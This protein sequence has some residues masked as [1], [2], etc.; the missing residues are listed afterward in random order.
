[1]H[2]EK[3]HKK[4]HEIKEEVLEQ[5]QEAK[6]DSITISKTEYEELLKFKEAQQKLIYVYAEFENFK[7]RTARDFQQQLNYANEGLIKEVLPIIDNLCRAKEHANCDLENSEQKFEKFLEGMDLI[8]KQLMNVL[9]KF[10]VEEVNCL[11]CKF[12]PEFHEA[13]EQ[14]DSE[15]HENGDIVNELQKGYTLKGRLIRPSKVSVARNKKED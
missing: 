6:S 9:N 13:M 2:K 3:H 5:V 15:E 1:M 10:G 7:K 8:L 11:G 14:V 12:N 4:E